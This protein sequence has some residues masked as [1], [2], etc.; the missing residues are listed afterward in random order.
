MGRHPNF[1]LG[2]GRAISA[3]YTQPRKC[4]VAAT[5][6]R[7]RTRTVPGEAT[8]FHWPPLSRCCPAG[9]QDLARLISKGTAFMKNALLAAAALVLV[10]VV[11]QAQSLQY[12]GFF[13]GAEAGG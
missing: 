1:T 10:P 8:N 6:P 4:G 3:R 7:E 12:P 9:S 2:T 13:A 11:S 5:G